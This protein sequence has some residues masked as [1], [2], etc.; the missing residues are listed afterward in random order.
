MRSRSGTVVLLIV[1]VLG[2]AGCSILEP[3]PDRSRFFVLTPIEEPAKATEGKLALGLGPITFPRYLERTEIVRRIGPN[4]V[5]PS[6]FDYWAGSL[7]NQ[8]ARVL[9]QNLQL[10][11]GAA[12]VRLHPWYAGTEIDRVVEVDVLRFE[13]AEDGKAHL[14]A[15]WRVRDGRSH[16][17]LA[18]RESDLSRPGA[19][20][21]ATTA[22]VLSALLADL[23][24]E[25]ASTI[26]SL[27]PPPARPARPK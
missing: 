8:F 11:V 3:K 20:D 21:A 6:T 4:E 2:C 23:S 10:T 25:M 13:T 26:E 16:D 22:S 18:S 27:P 24:R 9:A 12:N 15:R 1:A 14:M 7:P 5:K 19:H 17:V